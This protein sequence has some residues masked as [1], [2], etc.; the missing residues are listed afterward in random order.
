MAELVFRHER[1]T[2]GSA[3]NQ[4]VEPARVVADQQAVRTDWRF[5][6]PDPRT[7]NPRSCSEEARRPGRSA[8]QRLG[9]HM[10]RSKDCEQQHKP[11]DACERAEVHS[12]GGSLI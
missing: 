2:G 9:D 1:A 12:N 7:D 3:E 5:V 11:D 6:A 10:N 8:Q 4:Y